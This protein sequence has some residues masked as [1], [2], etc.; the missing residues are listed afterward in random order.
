MGSESDTTIYIW[1]ERGKPG[2]EKGFTD[3]II[4]TQMHGCVPDRD[5]N[6]SITWV[7]E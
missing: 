6:D 4:V 3:R 5:V 7:F 1:K 2:R